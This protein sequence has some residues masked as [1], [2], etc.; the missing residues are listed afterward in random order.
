M[1]ISHFL[2]IAILVV[3]VTSCKSEIQE[4]TPKVPVEVT[5]P[6]TIPTTEMPKY[7][8]TSEVILNDIKVLSSDDF[9]GRKTGT[10][11][12]TKAKNYIK[13]RFKSLNV[14]PLTENFEQAFSFTNGTKTYK[15]INVL[16]LI[17]GTA[18]TDKYIVLSGHYDHLGVIDG[19][20]FNGADDNASGV[21]ALLGFAEYFKKNPPKHN[22]IL[23]AFD[24]EEL[25][26]KGAYHYVKKPVIS[27][28][29]IVLNLNFDMIS[30]SD[31]KELYAVGTRYTSM[32][33]QTI[34]SLDKV[35]EVELLIGH[36]GLD[37]L[38]NWTNSSDHAAFYK[39]EIPFIYFGV[40]DHKDYHKATDTYD[41]INQ[42]FTLEAI[43]TI[44][45][46]FAKLD[47]K[48]L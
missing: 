24:G 26:L 25:G 6:P 15:G 16:G 40:P 33:K 11:G 35:G 37:S 22:V 18:N 34:T 41:K 27:L 36:E 31:S 30:R 29:K 2:S 42:Q 45:S 14:T 19:K 20:I 3:A 17:K 10:L 46:V 47:A 39:K 12:A 28:D 8:F 21:A 23:A 48:E 7:G 9:E 1:K 32:L 13:E 4:N 43:Q 5:T 38:E 44:I